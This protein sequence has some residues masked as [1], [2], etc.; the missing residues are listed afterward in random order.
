MHLE[1]PRDCFSNVSTRS[2]P[3]YDTKETV[4]ER[5]VTISSR[6]NPWLSSWCTHT[7][8]WPT[9]MF[10]ICV[11]LEGLSHIVCSG[12]LS[13]LSVEPLNYRLLT[14]AKT[15]F[16]CL[17][18]HALPYIWWYCGLRVLCWERNPVSGR[19]WE[20]PSK[21]LRK[22]CVSN[23]KGHPD[24]SKKR[25]PC[26]VLESRKLGNPISDKNP[27]SITAKPHE[28]NQGLNPRERVLIRS[29]WGRSSKKTHQI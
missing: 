28:A 14:R 23:S 24:S 5:D 16:P 25:P 7:T 9:N 29:R 10:E 13:W 26:R 19:W 2:W 1:N 21:L 4:G 12:W 18:L 22:A 3:K 27:I 17:I 15:V 8:R 6:T 11:S 20:D